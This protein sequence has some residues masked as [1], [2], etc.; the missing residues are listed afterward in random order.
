[1]T[2]KYVFGPVRSGRLG[3]SLGLDLL[4]EAICSLDCTY[5]EVGRT[6]RLSTERAAYVKAGDILAEL[7]QW[8]EETGQALDYVTLGGLG[9]PCLN[10]EMGDVIRGVRKILPDTPVAVLTNSTMLDDPQVRRELALADAV[11]PSMDTLVSEEMRKLNR[12]CKGVDVDSVARGLTAFAAEF[13]GDLFVEVLLVEGTNDSEENLA[14][15]TEFLGKLAPRRV[16][17][18]TMTRPGALHTAKPVSPE[19]LTRWREALEGLATGSHDKTT[20]SRTGGTRNIP[21][22]AA[23]AS[24]ADEAAGAAD[25]DDAARQRVAASIARRPQTAAQLADALALNERFVQNALDAL[26]ASDELTSYESG[27]ERFFALREDRG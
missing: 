18:V 6:T 5:C 10:S 3:L 17:V 21:T 2:Y 16:D 22:D 9:E 4:G 1:M 24:G 13:S 14:R 15:L 12:P 8:V 25:A 19:T 20:T 7:R 11:L 27:G 23:T 26:A